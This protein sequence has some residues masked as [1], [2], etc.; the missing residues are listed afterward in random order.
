MSKKVLE[1]PK[2][3]II[4]LMNIFSECDKENICFEANFEGNPYL[5]FTV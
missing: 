2:I 5:R 4:V 1:N 3:S